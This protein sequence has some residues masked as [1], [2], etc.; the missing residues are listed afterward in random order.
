[1]YDTDVFSPILDRI[2]ALAN[3]PYGE[4]E[5][6]DR[7]MRI[8]AEHVRAAT[9]LITDGV[10]PSNDGR[11][12]V[13]RRILRRAVYFLTQLTSSDETLL[14]KIAET[15][16]TRMER[17]YPDLRDRAGFTTRL[18]AAEES[19]FRET[20]ERGRVHLDEILTEAASD[21]VIAGQQAFMLYD[22]FGFPLDLT[23]EIAAQRGCTVDEQGF[24]R[25]MAAQ[26]ERGRAAAKFEFEAGRIAAYTELAQQAYPNFPPKQ[27]QQP[28]STVEPVI[29]PR[30]T[31]FVG[32]DATRHETTV[33][34]IIGAGGVQEH[35]EAG[36]EIEI[37]LVETPFYP[38]GGGQAGDCGDI[39]GPNGRVAVE[40]TQQAAEGL[41]VHRGSVVEG[42]VA[43]NDAVT[44]R[45]DESK[46]RASQ[47][48]HT[49]THLLHAALR[50]VLGTH[51][52]QAGSLVAPNRLRFDFTHIEAAKPEELAAVQRLVNEKIRGDIDVHWEQLPYAQAIAGG[53]MALF[54]E[55]YTLNVRVVGICETSRPGPPLAWP[56]PRLSDSAERGETG[57]ERCFSKELC[58]GTHCGRTGEIGAF[59]IVSE[60]SVGSG[61]RR[62]EA[63]TGPLAD[64]YIIEQQAR[65]SALSRRLNAP[66]AELEARI[67][68]LEAEVAAGRKRGEQLQRQAGKA[69]VDALIDAAERIGG[70]ALIVARV[71]VPSVDAMRE[72]GDLLREKLGSAVIVLG[73]VIDD[74]PNFLS[75][76]TRDLTS[77]VH[78]GN[79]IKQVAAVAGGGGGGRPEMAQAGGKDASKLDEALETARR[80]ARE[81]LAAT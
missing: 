63:L 50:Q 4:N 49:A 17:T 32:Y 58:G 13:L 60:G 80:I 12:Y 76:S 30:L 8:V 56:G 41:I 53:A 45:V 81:S 35:A 11:G 46:R 5:R 39:V 40:D 6:H 15:V 65:I 21:S 55:K 2:A 23:R 19:N 16:I 69:E 70:A 24:D 77:R 66:P 59:V 75:M 38:E 71:P 33:A 78:A 28:S 31:S 73:A 52:K 44:A 3:V 54:G 48:N 43:L 37:A 10:T 25:E 42:R 74:R 61:V 27:A 7:A 1:M 47:R 34:G 22:T 79:L 57:P 68:A 62:I 26:R 9:F 29:V 36:E 18:L 51:V 64:A 72:I 14:D 20:L 67:E